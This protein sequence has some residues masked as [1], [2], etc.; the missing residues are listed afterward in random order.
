MQQAVDRH[1]GEHIAEVLASR[2]VR[3][4]F[5][6][7]GGHISPVLVGARRRG[8]RV[9]DVRHEATAVFAA[10][11]VARLTGIPGVAALT[12]GP[13][14]TNA[15]T[16]LQNARM[17]PSSLVV[18]VGAAP[19]AL[20]GRGALQD[21]DQR[22]ILAPLAKSFR[23]VRRVADLAPAVSAAFDL[24][25]SGVPGPVV[26]ECPVD[27][28]YPE[29]VVREWYRGGSRAGGSWADRAVRW[30]LGR[31]VDRLFAGPER[32]AVPRDA[33]RDAPPGAT[34][35][36]A[37]RVL[38]S[39]ERPVLIVGSQ[40][41]LEVARVEA[42]AH[43][44]TLLGIPTYLS[45]TARGLLGR[46]HPVQLRHRRRDAL[47][48][49]DAVVLAGVPC[50]FRL[51][52]G[53]QVRRSTTLI[54]CNRSPREL[55]LNRVPEVAACCDPGAFLRDLADAGSWSSRAAWLDTL[56]SRDA[57]RDRDIERSADELRPE[58]ISPLALCRAI[59]AELSDDAVLVADGGDF[60]ATASYV[61]RPR[62]PLSW[63]D[64]GPFGTLGVGAGFAL[65][66]KLSRPER[67]VWLLWGDGAA[68]YGIAELDTFVRHGLGIVAVV[69]NDA[70]WSQIRREQVDILGDDVGC[71]L[72]STDY[73]RVAEGLGG[74]GWNLG[75]GDDAAR[76]LREAVGAARAGLPALINARLAPSAFR[77]GSVSM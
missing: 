9:V 24:A 35:A 32:A 76:V 75:P 52:Y 77:K 4:L 5:T 66:A 42:L 62:A 69:G 40:A 28:L 60:V 50:D 54:A 23:R 67:D 15:A 65:G 63:L 10:D 68:G 21:I 14:G 70:C 8:I 43:A 17:A 46:H 45:G 22:A 7:C 38:A 41:V 74:R 6:L 39:A 13:G 47:R 26:V 3:F 34:V 1:G 73:D 59:E 20:A 31:H 71:A 64:P 44:V 61:V 72:R 11:A 2:G 56:R 48:E 30:Y 57:D 37:A 49:A 53:R 25:S 18:L 16:A 36:R 27:L 55:R 33:P 19:T 12:A 58:G 51:D 29:A